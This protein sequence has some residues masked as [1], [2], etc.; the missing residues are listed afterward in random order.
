M[1]ALHCAAT[2]LPAKFWTTL[3]RHATNVEEESIAV[4]QMTTAFVVNVQKDTKIMSQQVDHVCHVL[5]GS[6]KI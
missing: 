2:A 4:V 6:S 5:L 1:S 3:P